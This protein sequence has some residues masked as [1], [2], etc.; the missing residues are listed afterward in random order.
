M[1]DGDL[2]L[3]DELSRREAQSKF[4]Y[5]PTEKE[6]INA[7][8]PNWIP[9]FR[10]ETQEDVDNDPLRKNLQI[11]EPIGLGKASSVRNPMSL[12]NGWK[13]IPL[14]ILPSEGFGYPPGF[15]IVIRPADVG[16][17]KHYST[18]DDE[19]RID[20]DEKM[21]YILSKCMKIKWDGGYLSHLDLWY[22]DRFFVIMSIRDLTFVKG[23]NRIMLPLNKKCK[24]EK[25]N[26]A[27]QIELKSN[28]L[29]SFKMDPEL[30]KRYA[31]EDY[32]FKLVPKDGSPEMYL[33]IPT[34][35]VTTECRKILKNKKMLGKKY[36]E[37]FAE[38]C[39]YVIPDWRE[40][41]EQTY[42][43]YERASLEWTKTQFFIADQISKKINFATKAAIYTTCNSC[44]EEA[45]AEIRFPGGY[46]SLFIIS[47]IFEQ[48]L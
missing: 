25:C 16:E 40:L 17:I 5:D 20:L 11:E 29:N 14:D 4:E 21:N 18:I 45:T 32:T 31:K 37:S 7:E 41:N 8:I 26:L 46:R 39:T 19:D 1:E 22:E 48:L 47:N 44:G 42:D 43:K 6:E 33:Y 23:E 13:N 34:V 28:M 36:D 38:V 10:E 15:E 9:E 24:G 27:D 35:G 3:M 12:E 2:T 30:V